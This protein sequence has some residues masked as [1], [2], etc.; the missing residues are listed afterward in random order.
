[1]TAFLETPPAIRRRR[2]FYAALV[3]MFG[4]DTA[5]EAI[6]IWE[7]AFGSEQPLLRG[8]SQ[9]AGLIVAEL[10]LGTNANDLAIRLLEQLQK[11]ETTLPPDPLPVLT[12]RARRPVADTTPG[13]PSAP[14]N[15]VPAP[16]VGPASLT[17]SALLVKLC[18]A[19]GQTDVR[20]QGELVRQ[21][22]AG[23]GK[24][25]GQAAAQDLSALLSGRSDALGQDYAQTEASSIINLFYVPLAELYGPITADRILASA[26]RAV[27]QMAVS[28]AFPPRDLL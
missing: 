6:N 7:N 26:V 27:E 18:D 14:T 23:S 28:R 4:R 17:L 13:V 25:F 10:K 12:G 19:A 20:S 2:A 22:V 3:P 21:F 15:A 11:D 9:F 1:M 24:R 16:R 8:I 5:L